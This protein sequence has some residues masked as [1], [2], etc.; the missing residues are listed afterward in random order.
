MT[1]VDW[2]LG[3]K[4]FSCQVHLMQR[5]VNTSG[6]GYR[7]SFEESHYFIK[8]IPHTH[9]KIFYVNFV[10][11]LV[12]FRKIIPEGIFLEKLWFQPFLLQQFLELLLLKLLRLLF[13]PLLNVMV[14]TKTSNLL[15]Q[16]TDQTREII[17]P[18]YF[19]KFSQIQRQWCHFSI[20]FLDQSVYSFPKN[21]VV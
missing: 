10:K 21:I 16:V 19:K 14:K 7:N 15:N 17:I 8:H 1:E 13:L 11:S 5:T 2:H 4:W 3:E 6:R 18:F 12:T 20:L 9:L